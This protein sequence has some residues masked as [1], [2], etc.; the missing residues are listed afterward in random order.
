MNERTYSSKQAE[1]RSGATIDEAYIDS[2]V[3]S[4]GAMKTTLCLSD[5]ERFDT[6]PKGLKLAITDEEIRI[7]G[8][9]PF[10]DMICI[11]INHASSILIA[12][13]DKQNGFAIHKS[14]N[15]MRITGCGE[16]RKRILDA[17]VRAPITVP[18]EFDAEV[19]GW[20][21]RLHQTH[22]P[23]EKG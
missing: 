7:R 23:G 22:P 12:L 5:F 15:Y 10:P 2:L 4:G 11:L 13:E 9:D 1:E 6:A 8:C 20:V 17:G 16:I 14:K 18:F 3:P 21:A 19:G